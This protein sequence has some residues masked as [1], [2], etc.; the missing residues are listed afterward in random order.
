MKNIPIQLCNIC[1]TQGEITPR[2]FRFEDE[3]HEIHTIHV[4]Q[5]ISQ[6]DIDFVGIRMIQYICRTQEGDE[7]GEMHLVE[8][9]YNIITH[10]WSFF[11]MLS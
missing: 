11:Q 6:K 5:I 7:Q 9:R 2:W 8:L 10:R 4:T 1:S 3:A